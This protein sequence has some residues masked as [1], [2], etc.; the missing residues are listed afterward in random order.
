MFEKQFTYKC[1]NCG[2]SHTYSSDDID[3]WT[4]GESEECWHVHCPNCNDEI[5]IAGYGDFR[6]SQ[7]IIGLW[8]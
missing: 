4:D 8:K 3:Y 1:L 6:G 5:V 7:K 2:F